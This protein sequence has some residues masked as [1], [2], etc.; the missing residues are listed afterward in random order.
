[1]SN[2]K[3]INIVSQAFYGNRVGTKINVED[4]DRFILGDLSN[5]VINEPIDRT[6][7]R[8]PNTDNIV[9]VYNKYKEE[10]RKNFKEEVFKTENH[11]IKPIAIIPENNIEIYSR[12]IVCR[13]DENGNL[14]SLQ[15][16]DYEEF[17]KYLAE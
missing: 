4:V 6:I 16:G 3:M 13:M 17:V 1:M 10:E 8:I 5:D 9:I 11:V 7:I 15:N 12:C 2:V 14:D